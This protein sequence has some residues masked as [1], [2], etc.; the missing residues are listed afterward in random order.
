VNQDRNV[1][2]ACMVA[3]G[4]ADAM[5][6]GLTRNSFDVLDEIGR[7]I[8]TEPERVVFGL[9][10]LL[11]RER[12]VLLADTLVHEVP[13]P[14]QLADIAVQAAAKAR[15]LGLE[16][17]VALLSY[18]NFGNPMGSDV[19][20]VRE[21]LALLDARGVDFEYD[22]EMSADVALDHR[23][24]RQLYPF[25]RLG[26]PAN[27]LVMPTLHSAN[28]TAKLVPQIGG[29]TVV[30]PLLIGLSRPV[31]IADMGAAV[32]DLVNLAALAAHDAI[33]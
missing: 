1:F 14:S 3:C 26:G 31:Q 6:T 27:I 5:V 4:D 15:Q 30:G 12:T 18:S 29:G 8:D 22:G 10:V 17:R 23:L 32:S 20:R 7:V 24:M 13:S 21:A 16:A 25:C 11:A 9:T 2:A 33:R 28:I 19:E